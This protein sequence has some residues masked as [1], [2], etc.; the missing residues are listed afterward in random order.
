MLERLTEQNLE[1]G[2]AKTDLELQLKQAEQALQT[3]EM[4]QQGSSE[5]QSQAL[6]DVQAQ[7]EAREATLGK[8]RMAVQKL[9]SNNTVL[10]A[11]VGTLQQQVTTLQAAEHKGTAGATPATVGVAD[12]GGDHEDGRGDDDD[13]DDD[14]DGDVKNGAKT[15][16]DDAAAPAAVPAAAPPTAAAAAAAAAAVAADVA[17]AVE[18]ATADLVRGHEEAL[19]AM[20][21]TE[22]D[23][24][25][26]ITNLRAA[27]EGAQASQKDH[28]QRS[29]VLEKQ[30]SDAQ[31]R[32]KV[33]SWLPVSLFVS[34]HP[35]LTTLHTHPSP[36]L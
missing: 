13:D 8:Y 7:L 17:A 25:T 33:R 26:E 18:A 2:S 16:A 9:K 22:R 27:V 5:Q 12:G 19:A 35:R 4:K 20:Q 36:F 21:A 30:V 6:R 29:L 14:G 24:N 32:R 15:A 3:A 34:L 11:R 23:L 31:T 10:Q 28:A 1:L